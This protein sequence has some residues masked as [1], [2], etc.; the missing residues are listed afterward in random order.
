MA[1]P[2]QRTPLFTGAYAEDNQSGICVYEFNEDSGELKSLD[3]VSGIKNPTFLNV[4]PEARRLYAIGEISEDGGKA[5]EVISFEIDPI[6][7]KL[8]EGAV[9]AVW[10]LYLP[11]PAR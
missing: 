6:A 1:N 11:Y 2:S 3:E 10:R 8:T 5:G 7:G 4:D 9:F